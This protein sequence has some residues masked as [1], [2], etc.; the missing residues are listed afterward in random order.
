MVRTRHFRPSACVALLA[1]GSLLALATSGKEQAQLLDRTPPAALGSLAPNWA[2]G[3]SSPTLSWLE[4]TADGGH[5]LQLA[6]LSSGQW[7]SPS[8][9]VTSQLFF[10]NWADTPGVV[11][12]TPGNLVA[13]WLEKNGAGTY[14]YGI[15]LARS[16]DGGRKWERIGR[17]HDDGREAEHGFVS[18]VVDRGKVRAFWLDGRDTPDGGAMSLRSAEVG[19]V[20]GV[21]DILDPRVCDCCQTGAAVSSAGPLVVFRDR[22]D[23]E[24]RDISIVRRTAGQGWS[25]PR[26]VA[27]D[28]WK[29]PG[30]PVNGP[31]VA[32]LDSRVAVAWFTGSSGGQSGSRVRLAFS[33]D[34]GESFATPIELDPD[35]PLG[36]VSL[37]LDDQGQAVVAWMASANGQAEVRLRRVTSTGKRS[38]ILAIGRS[39]AGRASGFPRLTLEGE[40]LFVVWVE[41][42]ADKASARLRVA[43]VPLALLP[44]P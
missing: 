33:T 4:P 12:A 7:K 15:E 37:V 43:E 20:V 34:A 27:V 25:V 36:R 42:G 38:P 41:A 40:N 32:T 29:I 35:P 39:T 11:Q 1:L 16:S 44:L 13:H 10:A 5:R 17:L 23:A 2:V 28:G 30:C 3:T 19:A 24:I 31:Q 21:S 18:W 26:P 8:T 6:E 9:V 22:S 14:A